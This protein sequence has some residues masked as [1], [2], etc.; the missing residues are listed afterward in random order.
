MTQQLGITTV[1][2]LEF[3]LPACGALVRIRPINISP[4]R[5]MQFV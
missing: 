5:E 2:E 4:Q 3:R 1:P